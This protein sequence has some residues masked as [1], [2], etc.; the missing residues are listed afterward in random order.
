ELVAKAFT[1]LAERTQALADIDLVVNVC[2]AAVAMFGL[3]RFIARFGVT[4]TLI[5]NPILMVVSFA[6]M[7]LSPTLLMLQ[8]MQALRRVTQYAIARPSREICFT[9]VE[10]ESRYKA[11][12][13]IDTVMYRLGDLTSAW[14]QAG[15]RMLGFGMMGALGLGV[16]ASGVWAI[17]AW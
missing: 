8:A 5:L 12:N 4:W 15:M 10:Q 13:I 9:V 14:V 16:L 3:S 17:S 6:L 2:S 11:K 7:A 1:D